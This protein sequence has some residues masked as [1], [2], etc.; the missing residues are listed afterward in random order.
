MWYNIITRYAYYL[1]CGYAVYRYLY[2]P[3][4]ILNTSRHFDIDVYPRRCSTVFQFSKTY[5]IRM[6]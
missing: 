4:G 3:V 2:R 1:Y 5:L 6:R